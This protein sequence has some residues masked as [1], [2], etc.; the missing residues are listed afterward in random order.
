M[1]QLKRHPDLGGDHA[2]ACLINQAYATLTNSEKR[3][4]YDRTRSVR[5]RSET[6]S[7]SPDRESGTD[8]AVTYLG[9]VLGQCVFC[10]AMQR[11][12]EATEVALCNVCMSPLCRAEHHVVP[13]SGR[14]SFERFSKQQPIRFYTAWP[15]HPKSGYTLDIS[16]CG[17]QFDTTAQL[18]LNQLIK[19]DCDACRALAR[20]ASGR[21][22][23]TKDRS[24][25]RVRAPMP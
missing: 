23:G 13:T 19:V 10:K 6:R 18:A 2:N 4:E 12:G 11:G 15:D 5:P 21:V 20:V 9:A 8:S 7:K 1:Q 16:L 25:L 17:M 3:A 14:R 24:P 22:L